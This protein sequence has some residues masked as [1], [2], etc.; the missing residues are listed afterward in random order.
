MDDVELLNHVNNY[1]LANGY[2]TQRMITIQHWDYGW[3]YAV[4]RQ[5]RWSTI[6]TDMIY[7]SSGKY[8]YKK[9]E[10]TTEYNIDTIDDILYTYRWEPSLDMS[11]Y[12]EPE[13]FPNLLK[14]IDF[15][16]RIN[17]YMGNLHCYISNTGTCSFNNSLAER[18][19]L[20]T[21]KLKYKEKNSILRY[22]VNTKEV[23]NKNSLEVAL[24]DIL[25][26]LERYGDDYMDMMKTIYEHTIY[27]VHMNEIQG[28]IWNF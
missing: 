5:K 4:D 14:Q 9:G 23:K 3:R 6:E 15:F 20:L 11:Y 2:Y 21:S 24:N 19:Y 10:N 17:K 12:H 18:I 28:T 27:T 26:G 16:S 13:L 22:Y 8:I 7:V 1:F 25:R